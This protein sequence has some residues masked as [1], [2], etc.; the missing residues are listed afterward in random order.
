MIDEVPRLLLERVGRAITLVS[1]VAIIGIGI[2]IGL[3]QTAPDT[4]PVPRNRASDFLIPTAPSAPADS[5]H[6][7]IDEALRKPLFIQGRG[8]DQPRVTATVV[9]PPQEPE[10]EIRLVGIQLSTDTRLALL[11]LSD[12]DRTLRAVEGQFIGSWMLTRIF[13]DHVELTRE[14]ET[15]SIYLGDTRPPGEDGAASP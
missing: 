2:E 9:S 11:R 3:S 10:P 14:S 8:I 5:S 7:A 12:A 4:S 15:R 13:G 6:A 1:V